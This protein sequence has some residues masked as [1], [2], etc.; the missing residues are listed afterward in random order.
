MSNFHAIVRHLKVRSHFPQLIDEVWSL[1]TQYESL[2][3]RERC[4]IYER[5]LSIHVEALSET[6]ITT[7]SSAFIFGRALFQEGHNTFLAVL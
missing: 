4:Q 7:N 3:K 1:N 5:F 6:A 2:I